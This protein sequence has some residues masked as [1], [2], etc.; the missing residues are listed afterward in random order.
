MR[1]LN[2]YFLLYHC[3]FL[4]LVVSFLLFVGQMYIYHPGSF[5]NMYK[6][7]LLNQMYNY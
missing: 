4:T 5:T 3:S 2:P 6:Y 1:K 7:I